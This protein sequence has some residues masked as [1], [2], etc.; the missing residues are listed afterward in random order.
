M[1]YV[2]A[3]FNKKHNKIYIGQTE[4]LEER[5]KLHNN[6][7]FT[8]SF[9]AHFS[10]D[11]ELIYEEKTNNRKEALEREKQ[12]KSYKGRQFIKNNYIPR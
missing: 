12:L 9:T 5:I 4:N 1:F 8:K 7:V 3:V 11:W 10:G 2:Y 6:K